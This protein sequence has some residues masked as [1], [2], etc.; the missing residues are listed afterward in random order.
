MNIEELTKS[1]LLLLMILISFV[2]SIATGILTVSLLDQAPPVVTQTVNRI[3]EHTVKTIEP[4]LPPAVVKTIIP[5]PAPSNEDLV[6]SALATQSARSVLLYAVS[7]KAPIISAGVYLP[8]VKMVVTM[9]VGTPPKQTKILF[10]NGATATSTFARTHKGLSLYSLTSI[11]GLPKAMTPDLIFQQNLKLGET[12]LA[13]RQD[14]GAVTGIIARI[15]K[16]GFFTTLPV[17]QVGIGVVNL[18]GNLVGISTGK[19]GLFIFADSV[20]ALLAQ[21]N[22]TTTKSTSATTTPSK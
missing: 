20:G 17:L 22:A 21:K 3:V 11:K 15:T 10:L 5:A 16:D 18:S 6:M 2:T 4:A 9:L 19:K 8:K 7:A 12:V 1:Q 13:I 14:G